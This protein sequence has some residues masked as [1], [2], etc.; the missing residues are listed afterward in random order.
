MSSTRKK[1]AR[2][3]KVVCKVRSKATARKQEEE[4]LINIVLAGSIYQFLV[5]VCEYEIVIGYE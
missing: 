2:V 1:K 3:P 4:C 5:R